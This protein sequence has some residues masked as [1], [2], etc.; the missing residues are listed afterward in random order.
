M[1]QGD[2]CRLRQ[3]LPEPY[4]LLEAVRSAVGRESTLEPFTSGLYICRTLFTAIGRW[5]G[6]P[7]ARRQ[8]VSEPFHTWPAGMKES[9]LISLHGWLTE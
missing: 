3:G 6:I 1:P 7:G 8:H 9:S 4:F 2:E 5:L